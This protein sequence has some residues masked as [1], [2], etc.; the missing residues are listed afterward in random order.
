MIGYVMVGTNDLAQ[1]SRFHELVLKPLALI[2][3]NS[4]PDHVAYALHT[5]PEAI[6]F[7]VTLLFD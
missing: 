4:N 1:E 2:R 7:C 6:E 5:V 3:F